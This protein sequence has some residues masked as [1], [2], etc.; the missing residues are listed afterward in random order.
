MQERE[1]N[2]K[3]RIMVSA[4]LLGIKCRYDGKSK[5]NK[6]V[7]EYC[8]DALII[9]FCPEQL[10]GL[11]T[12]RIKATITERDSVIN[13]AGE[14]VTENF[15]RGAMETLLIVSITKPDEIILKEGSPSCGLT[16]TNVNWERKKGSGITTTLLKRN[17]NIPLKS[18]ILLQS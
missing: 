9:P 4:C 14:D 3:K 16:E 7:I 1:S 15:H 11:S 2:S 12:P 5:R 18:E 6:D 10:G 17:T 8:K 13:F